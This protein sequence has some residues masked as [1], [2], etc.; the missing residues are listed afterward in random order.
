MV[1]ISDFCLLSW[2]VIGVTF[3]HRLAELLPILVESVL[4]EIVYWKNLNQ[5]LLLF[6]LIKAQF[7]GTFLQWVMLHN[8]VCIRPQ[9]AAS[10]TKWKSYLMSHCD[11]IT[12]CLPYLHDTRSMCTVNTGLEVWAWQARVSGYHDSSSSLQRP[13]WIV[14]M[15]LL[16]RNH[17]KQ[18]AIQHA[19]MWDKSQFS[20]TAD[21]QRT[22]KW[23]L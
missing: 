21:A 5:I 16:E 19:F 3:K 8:L 18:R 1:Y 10:H 2:L 6:H 9:H 22:V 14:Q 23:A 13:K 20:P 12:A 7:W 4:S 15:I 17:T 11:R